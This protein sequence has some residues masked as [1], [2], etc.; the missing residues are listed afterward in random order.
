M[1]RVVLVRHGETE[2]SASGRHTSHTDVPLTGRGEQLAAML[3]RRLGELGI[4][5]TAR[6]SSPRS[7]AVHTA[8]LAGLGDGLV[9]DERLRE[10]DYGEYEGRTTVDIHVERPTW[11]LF[12]DGSPGGESMAAAGARAD[13]LLAE[14][15]PEEGEGDVVLVGHG[16]FSRILAA[17]YLGFGPASAR[18][19]AL[20]TA[21][22]SVLG[23]EHAWRAVVLWND[24]VRPR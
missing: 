23:H 19:L 1:K 22:V 8:R 13:D 14:L 7:R 16:H 4:V 5:P 3:G 20:G 17:R 10:L 12:R 24:Q 6:L 21:S 15:A 18:H 11:D 2:W 9:I